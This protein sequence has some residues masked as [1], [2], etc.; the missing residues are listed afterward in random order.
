MA[1]AR[2]SKTVADKSDEH[3]NEEQHEDAQV[4]PVLTPGAAGIVTTD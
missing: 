2:D 4:A 1:T 3:C